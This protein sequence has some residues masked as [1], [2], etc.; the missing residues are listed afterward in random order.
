MPKVS[1]E[2]KQARR[3]QILDVATRCFARQGF[4]RTSMEDIIR[5]LK[6]SPGAVYCY[7]KGKNDIVAAIAEQRHNRESALL[8][9]L[10]AST[11]ISEGMEH[12]AGAFFAMLQ[13]PKEKA[14]RKV[15]IQI[16]A[17][18][19]RDK[20][21]RGIVER[22][23]RQ[24]DMLKASLGNAQRAG[25]LPRDINHDAL[26]RVLLALLQGFILQQAWEPE[27]DAEGYFTTVTR[28]M[29]SV[30]RDVETKPARTILEL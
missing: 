22:G 17:E 6:S 1:E 3:L 23:L 8:T 2:K 29:R 27:L 25:Q 19:L 14:R 10:I 7:F 9:E 4:H 13:D 11:D 26:S 5:E 16:W 21:I 30:F 15:T 18:S 24:R 12:L 20:R 28:L